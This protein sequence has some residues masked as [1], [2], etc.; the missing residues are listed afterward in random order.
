MTFGSFKI[1][2]YYKRCCSEQPCVYKISYVCGFISR[3]KSQK[4]DGWVKT[5][6][7]FGLLIYMPI[8][9]HRVMPIG[10]LTAQMYVCVSAAC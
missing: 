7:V 9:P 8:C 1:F 10:L 4:W 2:H 5:G 6:E 3:I